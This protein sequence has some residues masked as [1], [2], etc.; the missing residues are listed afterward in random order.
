MVVVGFSGSLAMFWRLFFLTFRQAL[1]PA[2]SEDSTL[3][4]YFVKV[5]ALNYLFKSK[6]LSVLWVTTGIACNSILFLE[7]SVSL[8][9]MRNNAAKHREKRKSGSEVV[10]GRIVAGSHRVF[11]LCAWAALVHCFWKYF[12]SDI[13]L[14]LLTEQG[15]RGALSIYCAIDFPHLISCFPFKIKAA[16]LS[17]LFKC[18]FKSFVQ[19]E[20]I[21]AMMTYP[22]I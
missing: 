3:C 5:M 9:A 16:V 2:S 20:W 1:W 15:E 13:F 18:F 6:L 17:T 19:W 7:K 21:R 4:R 12:S 14:S 8:L 11:I 22:K 10:G